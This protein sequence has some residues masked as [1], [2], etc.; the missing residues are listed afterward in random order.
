MWLQIE[1]M[2]TSLKFRFNQFWLPLAQREKNLLS[3]LAVFLVWV[4]L[5]AFLWLPMQHSQTQ[6]E[7][8]LHAA[9]Q[10]WQWLQQQIPAWQ[11]RAGDSQSVQVQDR[12]QLMSMVQSS[13][14][15]MNLHQQI[16][17]I[18]LTNKGVKVVF[19][20][21][22]ASR[23]F[24]WLATLEQQGVSSDKVQITPNSEAAKQ[25]FAAAQIDFVSP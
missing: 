1:Q 11:K 5:Y 17:S 13:L 20:D 24:Q 14:R 3:A 9:Q 25:G 7:Q 22:A 4:L 16:S 6:A 21:V 10:Q 12:N 18:D 19:K 2:L 8:K 15:Q 23:L